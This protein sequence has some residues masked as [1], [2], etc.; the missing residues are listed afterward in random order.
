M[1]IGFPEWW[2]VGQA[3][4]PNIQ[5]LM[6]KAFDGLLTNVELTSWFPKPSVYEAQLESG[7]A[8]LRFYRTGG[9]INREEKRDEPKVQIAALTRS[10]D[11]SWELIEFVRQVLEEGYGQAAAVVPGTIYTLY[12]AGEVVGP[13][14]IPE[15]L[16]DDRLVPI[17]YELH[18]RRP[19]GLP[20][21]RQALGL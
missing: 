12:A 8:Y 17:T 16:A 4:Y 1:A 21:Y 18:T 3:G 2:N 11:D 6:R 13:Q 9:R 5:K 19:K 7:G 14:L 10:S 20:N 15:L